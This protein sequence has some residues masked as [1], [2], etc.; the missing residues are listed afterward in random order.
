MFAAIWLGLAISALD[1]FTTPFEM[2]RDGY[3]ETQYTNSW[4]AAG[5]LLAAITLVCGIWFFPSIEFLIITINGITVLAKVGNSIH[6]LVQRPYLIPK[7]S[8]FKKKLVRP[9]RSSSL[10]RI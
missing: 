5:N 3:M 7:F 10:G 1:I 8:L 6:L 4:G 2:S 9:P